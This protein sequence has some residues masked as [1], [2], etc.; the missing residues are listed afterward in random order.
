MAFT[1]TRRAAG[2]PVAEVIGPLSVLPPS[3]PP[4]AGPTT[5]A[6][7]HAEIIRTA[8][9]GKTNL[10][11]MESFYEPA[12]PGRVPKRPRKVNSGTRFRELWSLV[13]TRR[14]HLR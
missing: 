4:S 10:N 11:I 6:P 13:V 2:I 1:F 9:S 12:S 5:A 3:V 8:A 7:P 14:R